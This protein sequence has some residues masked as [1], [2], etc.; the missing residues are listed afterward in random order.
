M[1]AAVFG[2]LYGLVVV[3]CAFQLSL[4]IVSTYYARRE[5]TQVLNRNA[6]K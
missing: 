5:K 2:A 1:D 6:D 4:L 3:T